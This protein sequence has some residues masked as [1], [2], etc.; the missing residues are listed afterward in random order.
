MTGMV[1]ETRREVKL[2]RLLFDTIRGTRI[3][4]GYL[5][6]TVHRKSTLND[7]RPPTPP[8]PRVQKNRRSVTLKDPNCG[9][10]S[11]TRN[12]ARTSCVYDER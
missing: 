3:R 2:R 12:S 8:Q 11:L 7:A 5:T 9:Y 4:R 6:V 10:S 1:K